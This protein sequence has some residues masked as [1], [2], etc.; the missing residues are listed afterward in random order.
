MNERE[1]LLR[2]YS[3]AYFFALD[4]AL[5]L[6]THPFHAEALACHHHYA[7]EARALRERYERLYG[8]LLQESATG[9]RCWDW[10]PA[11]WPWEIA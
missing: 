3:E 11:P 1:Q 2:D 8:P 7:A 10:A 9:A 4:V 5:F 6:D